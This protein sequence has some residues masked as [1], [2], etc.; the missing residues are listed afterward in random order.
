MSVA[1]RNR[2]KS[3]RDLEKSLRGQEGTQSYEQAKH[4][5]LMA[6]SRRY[7]E[8]AGGDRKTEK[9]TIST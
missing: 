1:Y 7:R 5:W 9:S 2:K 4:N 6:H 3:F 8:T